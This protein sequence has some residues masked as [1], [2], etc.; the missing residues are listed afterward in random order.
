MKTTRPIIVK[1]RGEIEVKQGITLAEW[2]AVVADIEARLSEIG[3]GRITVQMPR[4]EW[5]AR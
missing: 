4:G 1:L 3:V 2:A 5:P